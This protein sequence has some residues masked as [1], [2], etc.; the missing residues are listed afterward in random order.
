M[1][2]SIELNLELQ[3]F[4]IP[5]ESTRAGHYVTAI[6]MLAQE[7]FYKIE[8]NDYIDAQKEL[9][10]AINDIIREQEYRDNIDDLP[11]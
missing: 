3:S 5:E 6:K 9:I 4:A 11:F 8:E 2:N 10:D 1:R 7:L